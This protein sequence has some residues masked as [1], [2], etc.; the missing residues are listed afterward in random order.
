[1]TPVA[2]APD[3]PPASPAPDAGASLM[4]EAADARVR[5]AIGERFA[6]D[7]EAASVASELWTTWGIVADV[8]QAHTMDGGYR[9]SIRIEPAVP[10][11]ADRKHIEWIRAA[12]SDLDRFWSALDAVAP[13]REAG[14]ARYRWRPLT[15]RFMR[16]MNG[17]RTPSA[18]A[19]DW[20]VAWNLEGS[21]HT[22]SDAARE[23]LVHE[24]FHLNDRAH[25]SSGDDW[26]SERALGRD[27]DAIVKR[28]GTS[29]ACLA[30]F[31]PNHT[32]V[33]GGTYY[34]F[35][36]G[37]GV[38]E[39]AAELALRYYREQR[40]VLFAL[41]QEKAFKC[42][43]PENARAWDAMREEFFGG[44]DVVPPCG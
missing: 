32:T 39:Y 35:Q 27:Y 31:A 8:E 10:V 9:G 42:G 11:N 44:V 5:A 22:S 14:P 12:M 26:W 25:S 23:T 33:R 17:K 34:A 2:S 20:T 28:C 18:Y 37:N 43:P 36:P 19:H 38:V 3:V 13:S 21:L 29:R 41:K 16:S 6:A 1:V 30:P 24:I 4:A 7:P 15:L 40:S